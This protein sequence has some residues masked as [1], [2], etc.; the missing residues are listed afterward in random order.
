MVSELVTALRGEYAATFVCYPLFFEIS[1]NETFL[2][3][4]NK[5]QDNISN[6]LLYYNYV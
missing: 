6:S 2:V 4:G 1:F 5:N 3:D